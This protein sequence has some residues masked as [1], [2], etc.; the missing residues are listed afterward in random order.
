MTSRLAARAFPRCKKK[1]FFPSTLSF[2]P[3]RYAGQN[4]LYAGLTVAASATGIFP[5]H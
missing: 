2:V 3:F 5:V 4:R 1:E